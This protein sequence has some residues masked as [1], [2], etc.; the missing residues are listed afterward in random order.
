MAM[1]RRDGKNWVVI[2]EVAETPSSPFG[3]TVLLRFAARE[4]LQAHFIGRT[5]VVRSNRSYRRTFA[6][7][8][9]SIKQTASGS[10]RG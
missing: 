8:A 3:E 1:R 9:F 10:R 2:E 4:F 5:D 7:K 6:W